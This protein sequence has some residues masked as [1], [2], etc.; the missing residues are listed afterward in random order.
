[1]VGL[2]KRVRRVYIVAIPRKTSQSYFMVDCFAFSGCYSDILALGSGFGA[3]LVA[4]LCLLSFLDIV[5][6]EDLFIFCQSSTSQ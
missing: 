4:Q 2:L 1:M 6:K 3:M 5:P